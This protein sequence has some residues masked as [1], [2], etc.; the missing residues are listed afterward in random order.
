MR[1]DLKTCDPRAYRVDRLAGA[2]SRQV[3]RFLAL[4]ALASPMTACGDDAR[5]QIDQARKDIREQAKD[6]ESDI[7]ER[8]KQDLREALRD[9]EGTA[10]NGG[11]DAKR[12][13]RELERR[14]EREPKKRG[15]GG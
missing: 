11:A 3:P 15:A 6:I 9:A 8:S 5:D 12:E 7:D 1:A 14:I 10:Q 13:A 2:R 4:A